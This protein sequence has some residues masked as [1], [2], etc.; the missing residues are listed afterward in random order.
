MS[1]DVDIFFLFFFTI[2][3]QSIVEL[4]LVDSSALVVGLMILAERVLA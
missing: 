3:E 4:W 1:Y 2:R